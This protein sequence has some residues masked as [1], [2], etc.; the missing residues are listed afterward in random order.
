MPKQA[1]KYRIAGR[2]VDESGNPVPSVRVEARDEDWSGSWKSSWGTYDDL[3]GIATTDPGGRFH[4]EAPESHYKGL[5]RLARHQ[6]Q[7]VQRQPP[8]TSN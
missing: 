1:K 3:V 4:I 2:V 5:G 6:L 7:G 8:D